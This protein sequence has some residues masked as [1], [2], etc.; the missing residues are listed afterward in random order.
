MSEP[1]TWEVGGLVA[2]PA[3]ENFPHRTVLIDKDGDPWQ[4]DGDWF[5]PGVNGSARPARAY[6]PYTVAWLPKENGDG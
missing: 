3:N 4:L 5:V 2:E 1:H 6:G